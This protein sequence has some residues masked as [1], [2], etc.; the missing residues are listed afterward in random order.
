MYLL[1]QKITL[2]NYL[3]KILERILPTTTN[4]MEQILLIIVVVKRP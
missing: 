1:D 3:L 2:V 4:R